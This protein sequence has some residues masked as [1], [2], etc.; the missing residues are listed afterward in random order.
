MIKPYLFT[1]DAN[2]VACHRLFDLHFFMIEKS[3]LCAFA[4]CSFDRVVFLLIISSL[5]I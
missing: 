3:R 2:I 1:L 5:Q 4:F